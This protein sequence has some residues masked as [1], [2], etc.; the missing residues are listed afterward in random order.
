M[1]LNIF[2]N[3]IERRQFRWKPLKK[4]RKTYLFKCFHRTIQLLSSCFFRVFYGS[5]AQAVWIELKFIVLRR[6]VEFF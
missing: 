4:K 2:E 5:K 3:K 6:K 1:F